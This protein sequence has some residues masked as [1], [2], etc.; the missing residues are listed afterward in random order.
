MKAVSKILKNCTPPKQIPGGGGNETNGFR[1]GEIMKR[2]STSIGIL[3]KLVVFLTCATGQAQTQAPEAAAKP[4]N[5]TGT[6]FGIGGSLG[7]ASR[8]FT[9][10]INGYTSDEDYSRYSDELKEFKQDGLLKA[11]RK[12]KKG[13]VA[14]S[15]QT[16]RDINVIRT[17]PAEGGKRKVMI[18]FERW[19]QMY[20]VRQGTRSVDYP[21]AFGEFYVDEKGKGEGTFIPMAKI[22]YKVDKKTGKKD[23]DLENFGAYPARVILDKLD[24]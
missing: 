15:G 21:F 2:Y 19:I 17:S 10:T 23:I 18:L 3:L 22:R 6:V 24:K 4:E 9:L 5:Y 11:I 20:E 1:N 12:D 13:W 8:T 16:A 14:V 7:G